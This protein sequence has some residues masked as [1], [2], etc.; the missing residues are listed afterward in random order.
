MPTLFIE[1]SISDFGTWHDAFT[2]LRRSGARRAA[3]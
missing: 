1:H 2:E 3:C